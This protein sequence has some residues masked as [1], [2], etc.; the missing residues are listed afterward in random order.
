MVYNFQFQRS[1]AVTESTAIASVI[2]ASVTI[3]FAI[4]AFTIITP[5]P[6]QFTT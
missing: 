2:I 4:I 1:K 6:F 3:A 5:F